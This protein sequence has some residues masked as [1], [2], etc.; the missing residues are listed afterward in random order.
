LQIAIAG[1]LQDVGHRHE[2]LHILLR[3]LHLSTQRAPVP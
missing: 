2:G 3:L 1:L